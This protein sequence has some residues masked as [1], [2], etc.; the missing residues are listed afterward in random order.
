MPLPVP[1]RVSSAQALGQDLQL[2]KP[3]GRQALGLFSSPPVLKPQAAPGLFTSPPHGAL[4]HLSQGDHSPKIV[5]QKPHTLT[6]AL[7]PL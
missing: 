6:P 2:S 3:G 4:L 5:K 1:A 7:Q